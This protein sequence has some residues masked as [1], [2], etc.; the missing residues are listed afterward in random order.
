M[1][2]AVTTH[3]TLDEA[4]G[5]PAM[6]VL[7]IEVVDEATEQLHPAVIIRVQT[8]PVGGSTA[9]SMTLKAFLQTVKLV[10]DEYPDYVRETYGL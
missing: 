2:V 9:A 1:D 10:M 7:S 8:T 3:S 4:G 5:I 6:G